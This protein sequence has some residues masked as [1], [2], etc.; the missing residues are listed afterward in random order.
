[1]TRSMTPNEKPFYV[2]TVSLQF[3][4]NKMKVSLEHLI[5]CYTY[6]LK[7]SSLLC[8]CVFPVRFCKSLFMSPTGFLI[9]KGNFLL[10]S[11]HF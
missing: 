2:V 10:S 1:M 4:L 8:L 5:C 9:L 3:E 7:Y 6:L 11:I